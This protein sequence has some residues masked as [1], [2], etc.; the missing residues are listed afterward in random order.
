MVLGVGFFVSESAN[1]N[2]SK[3]IKQ[4]VKVNEHKNM[5]AFESIFL[6]KQ[7]MQTS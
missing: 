3:T 1:N 6:R 5:S 2:I 4:A 7:L